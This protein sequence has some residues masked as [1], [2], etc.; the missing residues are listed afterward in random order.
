MCVFAALHFLFCESSVRVLCLFMWFS[1]NVF[2]VGFSSLCDEA[3]N[4]VSCGWKYFFSV[5]L[6]V[7]FLFVS[8]TDIFHT[9]FCFA[10]NLPLPPQLLH[11]TY[12]VIASKHVTTAAGAW[13]GPRWESQLRHLP[14]AFVSG[15]KAA[16]PLCPR[17]S[18][19]VEAPQRTEHRAAVGPRGP[20]PRHT[21]Q[22][23]RNTHT[24]TCMWMLSEALFI[25]A[26]TME[27]TQMPI[28]GWTDQQN[29][30]HC[31]DGT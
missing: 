10:K 18:L 30:S 27:T 13:R 20:T 12:N 14:T 15:P 17:M 8:L 26:K 19:K 21:S 5:C 28:G 7:G 2:M 11:M 25:I 23:I 1:L 16:T 24:N 6:V 29:V 22:R 31:G 3:T 9:F 4:P